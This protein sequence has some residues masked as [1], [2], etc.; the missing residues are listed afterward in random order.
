MPPDE[1][2]MFRRRRRE[3]RELQAKVQELLKGPH[4]SDRMHEALFEGPNLAER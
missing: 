3:I 4:P 1:A 2:V